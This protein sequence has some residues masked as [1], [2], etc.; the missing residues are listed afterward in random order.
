M[1]GKKTLAKLLARGVNP[2]AIA[3]SMVRKGQ[4]SRGKKEEVI[5]AITRDTLKKKR[6][7][8]KS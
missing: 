6:R 7:R 8:K 1:P 3:N 2:F 5:Q 4:I